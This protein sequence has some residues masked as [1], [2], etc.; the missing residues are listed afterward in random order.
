MFSHAI[1]QA[2]FNFIQPEEFVKKIKV[3]LTPKI[4]IGEKKIKLNYMDK[5]EKDYVY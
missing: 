4:I 2:K 3:L 1:C 5:L